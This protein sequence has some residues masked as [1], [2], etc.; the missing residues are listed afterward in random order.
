MSKFH[1]TKC[2]PRTVEWYVLSNKQTAAQFSALDTQHQYGTVQAIK[3]HSGCG[4][5]DIMM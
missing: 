5:E 3:Y 2:H 4:W 1:K